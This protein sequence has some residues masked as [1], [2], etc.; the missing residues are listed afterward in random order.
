M[1][2]RAQLLDAI[3][4]QRNAPV[5]PLGEALSDLGLVPVLAPRGRL[6]IALAAWAGIGDI[7]A[8]DLPLSHAGRSS[9]AGVTT[10]AKVRAA[11][12]A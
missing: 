1:H 11:A 6:S 9:D 2:S 8:D 4:A 5:H 7:W 3:E 12:R 10:I